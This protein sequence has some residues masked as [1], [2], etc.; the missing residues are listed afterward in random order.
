[1]PW[2]IQPMIG[3][4]IPLS[5]PRRFVCDLVTLAKSF[6]TVP[7]QRTFSLATLAE[8]R[9]ASALKPSW[10]AIFTLAYARVAATT[11][12]LRRFY[13]A[14]PYARLYELP[15]SVVSIAIEREYEGER[16]V[17]VGKK[18][19]PDLLSL[20]DVQAWIN[21][22]QT[23]PIESVKDFRRALRIAALPNL[24]R[25]LL[26]RLALNWPRQRANYFGTFGV[27][28]YSSLG[29]ESLHPIAPCTT[30]LTYGVIDN[31]GHVPVRLIYDHR[32]MDGATVARALNHLEAELN[33]S[34][35]Q[36]LSGS[37]RMK[38]AA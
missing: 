3:K 26:W 27:S 24:V 38:R 30:V 5:L 34:I 20:A 9:L 23:A 25:Q 14:W 36:E 18:R 2:W 1:M 12:E 17:F 13:V 16:C 31:D 8:V 33:G 4:S 35:L 6:P 15:S 19:S 11:P 10:P 28:V 7:V 32:V 29:A 22:L 21:H 37:S